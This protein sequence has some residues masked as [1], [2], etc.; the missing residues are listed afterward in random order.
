MICVTTG[1]EV[2]PDVVRDGVFRCPDCGGLMDEETMKP[3]TPRDWLTSLLVD[4]PD[5]GRVREIDRQA[6]H[7]PSQVHVTLRDG[8]ELIV[9]IRKIA[10]E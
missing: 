8:T 3:L 4:S 7:M 5:V 1:R 6:R 10:G 2:E 9:A